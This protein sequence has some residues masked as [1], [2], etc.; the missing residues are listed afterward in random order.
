MIICISENTSGEAVAA[1]TPAVHGLYSWTAG[2]GNT[3][4]HGQVGR[5]HDPRSR[6]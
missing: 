6:R 5:A 1:V 2:T 4:N 3:A